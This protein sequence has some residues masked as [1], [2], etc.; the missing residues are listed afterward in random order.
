MSFYKITA[1]LDGSGLYYDPMEP[2]HLD[3]LLAWALAPRQGIRH[4]DR[5]GTPDLVR[6]PV[7]A[8]K[9]NGHYIWHA[10]AL[11]P[12]G[13]TGEAIWYWRKRFRQARCE[14]TSGA[15]N[16]TNGTYRDWQM[17][18]PLLMCRKLVG[19]AHGKR[20]EI[21]KALNELRYIGKKRAHGHGKVLLWDVEEAPDDYSLTMDGRAMRWLPDPDGIREVRAQP[22]YWHSHG[23]VRCC[24]VGDRINT[25]AEDID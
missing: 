16:L 5:S 4:L 19:Y 22:P 18:L 8:S 15:P 1:H 23:R 21:R 6:L 9:I 10:S 14:L 13:P 12:A 7:K 11:F 20:K 3:A 17:P 25:A 24:D 2:P